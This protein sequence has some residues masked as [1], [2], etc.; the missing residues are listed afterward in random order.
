[1]Y[2]ITDQFLGMTPFST[3]PTGPSAGGFPG[4]E[5]TLAQ[6]VDQ[7]DRQDKL[8]ALRLLEG[9]DAVSQQTEALMRRITG[10]GDFEIALTAWAVLLKTKSP[11]V[12]AGL[13]GYLDAHPRAPEPALT[14]IGI[15][16]GLSNIRDERAL[17]SFE[18]LASSRYF[19]I[20]D[21]ALHALRGIKDP[22]SVP[23]LI[24]SLDDERPELQYLALITLSETLGKYE[25]DYAPSMY[26]FDKK[27]KYYIDLWKKWWVDEGSKLYPPAHSPT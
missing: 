16:E 19:Q 7:S 4:L 9:F 20:R 8:R 22:R 3:I 12:V 14:L 23:K 1:M 27:P 17:A 26:L 13:L 2:E 5:I 10:S 25:G 6:I 15:E 24:Q 21:G 11:D 18:K